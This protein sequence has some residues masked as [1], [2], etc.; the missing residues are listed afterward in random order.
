[1]SI[2]FTK[3][4]LD[5]HF[6]NPEF[7]G[8]K[9]GSHTPKEFLEEFGISSCVNAP[10]YAPFC[11]HIFVPNFTDARMGVHRITEE[12]RHLLQ[13]DYVARRDG[14]LPILT[15]WFDSKDVELAECPW[16]DVILYSAE[17]LEKEGSPIDGSWGIVGILSAV[18]PDEA[19]MPPITAMRNA[20]GK[21]EGGS[22]VALDREYYMRAVEY[23]SKWATIK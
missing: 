21:D 7:A 8:T 16:L 22:G 1:L 13:S 3:F 19:P 5:R 17:Q 6:G 15:R 18:S 12:N 14:E 23:W 11:R 10:G 20:L 2:V 4:A 9:V